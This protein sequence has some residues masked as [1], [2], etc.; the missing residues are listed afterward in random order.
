MS[1]SIAADVFYSDGRGPE[2]K[3]ALWDARG[4]ALVAIDYTDPDGVLRHVRFHGPQVAMFTPEEVVGCAR[5]AGAFESNRPTAA[6]DLGQSDWLRTFDPRHLNRCRH[7]QLLFYDELL[8]IICERL[9]FLDG[10][11][12]P[13]A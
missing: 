13:T 2:L 10:A 7:F 1:E 6:I 11:F 4:T 3:R 12:T 9:E 8:D 5:Q